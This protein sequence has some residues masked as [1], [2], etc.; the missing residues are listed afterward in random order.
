ML[1]FLGVAIFGCF[2]M[3]KLDKFLEENRKAIAKEQAAAQKRTKAYTGS[4]D[5]MDGEII[6]SK[7]ENFREEHSCTKIIV[8]DPQKPITIDLYHVQDA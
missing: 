6:E 3:G 1:S 4:E 7:I 5:D 2:L 8:C